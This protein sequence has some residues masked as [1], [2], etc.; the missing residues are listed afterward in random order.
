MYER[1]KYN[2]KVYLIPQY[3][4]DRWNKEKPIDTPLVKLVEYY[5]YG[6]YEATG[7]MIE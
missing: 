3:E 7:I 1:V 5:V 2:G 4:V 6:V